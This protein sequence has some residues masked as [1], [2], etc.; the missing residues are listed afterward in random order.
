MAASH[1]ERPSPAAE[2]M[3]MAEQVDFENE[4]S[5]VIEKS[6]HRGKGANVGDCVGDRLSIVGRRVG[7]SQLAPF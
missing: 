7:D 2:R 6:A 1:A 4:L 5:E 3:S